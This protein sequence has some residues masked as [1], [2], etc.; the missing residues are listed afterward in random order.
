M[1]MFIG[2]LYADASHIS[3]TGN[4]YLGRSSF[5]RKQLQQHGSL[6]YWQRDWTV[7]KIFNSG[8]ESGKKSNKPFTGS[9]QASNLSVQ[10]K[11]ALTD[12]ASRGNHMINWQA[13][14]VLN[15][16]SDRHTRWIKEAV[17]YIFKKIGFV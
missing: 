9:Q 2:V 15:R 12:E 8:F 7:L 11:S 3:L 6:D 14:V 16:E 17:A 13:S 5:Y 1:A 4:F 10:N